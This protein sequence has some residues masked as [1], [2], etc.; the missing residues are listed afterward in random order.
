MVDIT[1]FELHL[2][3]AEFTANAPGSE[4]EED[5]DVPDEDGGGLPLGLFAIA[6]VVAVLVAALAVKKMRGGSSTDLD[7][8]ADDIA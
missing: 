7:E 1:I 6:G 3:G 2:D 5:D 4:A 8:I